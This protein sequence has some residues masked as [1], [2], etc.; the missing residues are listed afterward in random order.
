MPHHIRIPCLLSCARNRAP[1]IRVEP[2]EGARRP[3]PKIKSGT[4]E[5]DYRLGVAVLWSRGRGK[6]W[7]GGGFE[8]DLVAQRFELVD[9]VTFFAFRADAVV[10]EVGTQVVEAGL[11]I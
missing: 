9:V 8:G 7:S 4:G 1:S 5:R 2:K 3:D 11:G 6:L 10:V